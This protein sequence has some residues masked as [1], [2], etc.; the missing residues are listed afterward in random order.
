MWFPDNHQL[1]FSKQNPN[2]LNSLF[3]GLT[4]PLLFLPIN[5]FNVVIKPFF[6]GMSAVF[7]SLVGTALF[8][9]FGRLTTRQIT[10]EMRLAELA[11]RAATNNPNFNIDEHVKD[12][13]PNS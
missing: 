2:Y 8:G 10:P 9:I 11:I 1:K 12:T 4:Q 6:F 13:E 7:L 3:I 5:L